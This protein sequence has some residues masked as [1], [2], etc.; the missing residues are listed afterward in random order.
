MK[1]LKKRISIK[2][3]E[4]FSALKPGNLSNRFV[5]KN[6]PYYSQWES[7]SL[8]QKI[9]NN[10][11]G[12]A[13]DPNWKKSGAK[14]KEE[15]AVWSWNGCGMACLKMVLAY[16]SQPPI[17]LAVLGKKSLKY[18]VYKLPLEDSDGMLYKPFIRFIRQEYGLESKIVA[19]MTKQN[20]ANAVANNCLVIASVNPQI[21]NPKSTPTHKGGHLVLVVGYDLD[22]KEFYLHNPSGFTKQAQ[23]YA[24]I[25]FNDF[26]KFFAN[27]GII[28]MADHPTF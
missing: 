12:A 1:R 17:P 9:V 25:S 4:L 10:E 5:N 18:G 23:K 19:S 28:V 11:I 20:I 7:P 2:T 8:A 6:V 16:Q 15:Y 27:Q 26:D 13:E 21:R 14:N 3:K 24:V 22:K